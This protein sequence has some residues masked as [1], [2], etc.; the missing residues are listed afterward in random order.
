ML[1]PEDHIFQRGRKQKRMVQNDSEVARLYFLLLLSLKKND[2]KRLNHRN[3]EK[4]TTTLHEQRIL[5]HF[6]KDSHQ[7]TDRVKGTSTHSLD[8][9][10]ER[11]QLKDTSPRGTAET[12][13]VKPKVRRWKT[14][15][16][17]KHPVGPSLK[18]C[19]KSP[20]ETMAVA[21]GVGALLTLAQRGSPTQ[22]LACR[23]LQGQVEAAAGKPCPKTS[24]SGNVCTTV[25]HSHLR[26]VRQESPDPQH[27]IAQACKWEMD[28]QK[29]ATQENHIQL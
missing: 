10:R 14:P 18:E 13:T 28:K 9:V 6:W 24:V 29:R 5:R 11:R 25:L 26:M 27:N 19:N 2:L 3:E 4:G 7:W 8:R 1:I 16:C 17:R 20:R 22:Q 12:E 23:L 21:V 15:S